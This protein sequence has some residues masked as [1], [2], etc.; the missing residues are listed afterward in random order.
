MRPL[1]QVHNCKTLVK[2]YIPTTS[3]TCSTKVLLYS[4]SVFRVVYSLLTDTFEKRT[5]KVGPRLSLL[6]LFDSLYDGHLVPVPKVSA[7][8]RVDCTLKPSVSGRK[9]LLAGC[10]HIRL[11]FIETSSTPVLIILSRSAMAY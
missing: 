8:E 3:N 10:M 6:P 1:L 4:C 7:L 9:A 5:P 11:A 2:Y